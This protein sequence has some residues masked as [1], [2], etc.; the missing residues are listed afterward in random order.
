MNLPKTHNYLSITPQISNRGGYTY[1][2]KDP[3]TEE[4]FEFGEEEYFI[5]CKLDGKTHLDSIQT[6]F[7]E[8]FNI[9]LNID[10]L[11]AFVRQLTSLGLLESETDTV[12]D[13]LDFDDQITGRKIFNPDK[14]LNS[15]AIIFWWCFSPLFS[16]FICV[17]LF[18]SF[19]VICK[20]GNDFINEIRMVWKPGF[21]LFVALIG[22]FVINII[23]EIAKGV[24]CKYYGGY[25]T[26]FG[27]WFL[28]KVIPRFYCDVTDTFWIERKSDRV[29][30]LSAGIVCQFLLWGVCIIGW[31][32]TMPG[33][34]INIFWIVF[35]VTSTIYL[36]LNVNPLFKRDGYQLLRIW[37]DM[38]DLQLRAKALLKSRI[39]RKPLP[40]PLTAKE[41]QG[42]K[43]YGLLLV[44]FNVLFW[45]LILGL[46]GYF[47]AS[48]LKG[49]GAVIFLIILYC[50]FHYTLKRGAMKL[51]RYRGI[52]A[53]QAGGVSI[54]IKWLV[55][56][57][58]P[59]VFIL[60]MLIPYP[61]TVGGAF[62]LI[63]DDQFG[64]RVQVAGEIKEVFVKEGQ[65]VK[66]GDPVAVLVGRD[67][68]KR[69]EEVQ[70]SLDQVNA[71]L[72]LLK[73]GAKPEE[74]ARAEQ[75]VATAAKRLQYSQLEAN[76]SEQMFRNKAVSE[77]D[78][79]NALKERDLDQEGLKL[80]K[81]SL[82]LVK[83]GARDEAIEALE[84]EAR[85]LEVNLVHAKE[86][87]QLTTILSLADGKIITPYISQTIGQYLSV[88]DLFAVVENTGCIIAEIEVFE[89]DIGEVQIGA[90]TKLRTWAFPNTLFGGK[91]M[92]IAPVA[93]EKSKGRI[94]RALSEREWR[95]EQ[96]EI[97]RK[98]GKVI[99]VLSD[100]QNTNGML[101]TDMTGYAK[102][103]CARRP[104]GIAFTRWLVRFIFVEV[105]SWIP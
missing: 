46:I 86:D 102:I 2:V 57:G 53:N 30:I 56:I 28:Y 12:D 73:E 35:T 16:I 17:V 62:R 99:R 25:V 87:L 84:A 100:L 29:R 37:L 40:E 72:Q 94:D 63:P 59:I 51:L 27:I 85:L 96:K 88:G 50:R 69:V 103:E 89:E 4:F 90:R 91:V 64:I 58:L 97:L 61:F 5:F 45:M 20:Y 31:K 54:R 6:D 21:F 44:G 47:L 13:S 60:I 36:F 23:S 22:I 14:L 52:L 80:A 92:S 11:E 95:I 93:Y 48:L 38:P 104:L 65:D 1:I 39:F 70:A 76:R 98:E 78:Y 105:W 77:K 68:K 3:Q 15:L 7:E 55:R 34:N 42:F 82:Q 49:V 67:Q 24:S 74:I 19:G 83:S 32:N 26:T 71:R 18:L 66:K 81:K 79:E 75:E 33:S 101:K 9:P 8:H 43:W 10:Y 41:I